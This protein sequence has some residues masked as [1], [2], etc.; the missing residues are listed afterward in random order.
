MHRVCDGSLNVCVIAHA[1]AQADVA[2][3]LCNVCG[4]AFA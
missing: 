1:V 4:L 3:V 2:M